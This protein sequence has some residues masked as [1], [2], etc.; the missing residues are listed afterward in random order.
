MIDRFK[1]YCE[2]L[3]T[4]STEQLDR[5]AEKLVRAEKRNLA[6]L[7]AHLAEMSRRKGELEQ[8][9]K[10]LFEYWVKR[11]RLSEGSV[12]RRLQVANVSR[13]FPQLL[14]ALAENRI[15]LTVA[16][17]LAPHLREDNVE[18]LVS[19]CAGKTKREVEEYL[20]TLKPKPV[21]APSIRR[22][23]SRARDR[24]TASSET[25]Q[26]PLEAP[27]CGDTHRQAADTHAA[28]A[29]STRESSSHKA[30]RNVLEP[31]CVDTFN[32]RFAANGE[33]KQKF[34]RLAEVPGIENAQ[35]NMAKVLEQAL[36]IALDKKDPKRKRERRLAKAAAGKSRPG[37][38][39]TKEDVP[40]GGDAPAKSRYIP[41]DVRERVHERGEYQCMFRGPDGTR[42]SSRTG[43]E[44]EHERPF[45]IF[46]SH[47]ERFL[48]LLCKRH[49]G[50][51]AERVF[52]AE[53]I[54][55]KIDQ[56]R[57]QNVSRQ[58]AAST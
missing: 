17:L 23:P 2:T 56:R 42:C 44:V 35:K 25:D 21:F 14:V 11:L 48:R 22:P 39:S 45:G 32:F 55:G 43:L 15:S 13:R 27:S 50:F 31:A 53:F 3:E 34:E 12:A 33:F 54:Q 46:R 26:P 6:L 4:L 47:E 38:I 1:T 29:E 41:P 24:R 36:D 19:D 58:P 30:S 8:G 37:K 10:N 52:G 20:V 40:Q 18:K 49:N 57:R 16:G 9:Y 5:S 51:M 28:S 7:I